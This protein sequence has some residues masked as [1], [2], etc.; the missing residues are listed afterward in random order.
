MDITEE[1]T[2]IIDA[3][4]AEQIPYAVCGG[5]AVVLY[6]GTRL[7][8]D[9]DMLIREEDLD[10]TK[11]VV[12]RLGFTIPGGAIT[13]KAGTSEEQRL[14]RVSKVEGE[15]FL[16]LD[17]MLVTP[18]LGEAWNSRIDVKHG[19]RPITVIGR[20]GLRTMKLSAGR[21]KDLLDLKEIGISVES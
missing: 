18:F 13:F 5:I 15:E 19:E 2:A 21:D 12:A 7:T 9:I 17:L 8:I 16:T 3:M 6:G 11:A 14:F 20:E 1:F 4:N 10:R